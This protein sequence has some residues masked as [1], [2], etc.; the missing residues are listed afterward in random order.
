MSALTN[1]NCLLAFCILHI[2]PFRCLVFKYFFSL[3]KL[4]LYFCFLGCAETF[5][6]CWLLFAIVICVYL[7]PIKN[8]F[9]Q[10]IP[11]LLFS[12]AKIWGH[13]YL[14]LNTMP[15]ASYATW[16]RDQVSSVSVWISSCLYILILQKSLF[17][18]CMFITSL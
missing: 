16:N 15:S 6:S 2:N 10:P 13:I 17:L 4:S 11:D 8:L 9:P 18:Y 5:Q 12:L 3:L 1:L 7:V 14:S